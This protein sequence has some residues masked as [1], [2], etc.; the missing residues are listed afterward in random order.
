MTDSHRP[1]EAYDIAF[2]HS[3]LLV[4]LSILSMIMNLIS[5]FFIISNAIRLLK[6]K[7]FKILIS[8]FY[9]FADLAVSA[10]IVAYSIII[11]WCLFKTAKDQISD[12]ESKVYYTTYLLANFFQF[13]LLAAV[14]LTMY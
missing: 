2:R 8:L 4:I 5:T 6:R 11:Y 14:I 7:M 1:Q 9:I 10:N 13:Y 12:T 3:T